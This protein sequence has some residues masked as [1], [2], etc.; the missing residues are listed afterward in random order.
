MNQVQ[1]KYI[2]GLFLLVALMGV[3]TLADAQPQSMPVQGLLADS[4]GTP[5]S[6]T[7]TV[8]FRIYST[9]TDGVALHDETQAIT[10]AEGVFTAYL[11][12]TTTLD[13]AI[14]GGE[15]MWLGIKVDDDD[16]MTPRLKLG[17][18]PYAAFAAECGSVPSGSIMF[19][20]LATCPSSWSRF[21][22]LN[23]R[24]PMGLPSGGTLGATRGTALGNNQG[25]SI[26]TVV[27]HNHTASLTA[28]GSHTHSVNPA[29]FDTSTVSL[30]HNHSATTGGG[31][32]R[33][34]LG[35]GLAFGTSYAMG[36]STQASLNA[37][38]P[39]DTHNHTVSVANASP[40]HRHSIN[41]P[42][43]TSS[44]NPNHSHSVSVNSAGAATVDV[45]MPYV[46]LLACRKD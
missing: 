36:S 44:T 3:P 19:F 13:L 15:E 38:G 41:V 33:L 31:N 23:G 43:T 32:L 37:L 46:Q 2:V 26:S 8:Q 30:P 27:A 1:C 18:V 10:F 29:P 35:S 40:T 22:A 20:E 28:A 11:G 9:E 21:D 7:A 17:T 5:Y 6:A 12:A 42:P 14:F 34:D 25:R 24:M 39:V 4:S 45:T 16:E